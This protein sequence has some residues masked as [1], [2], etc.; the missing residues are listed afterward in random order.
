MIALALRCM[1]P[2]PSARLHNAG[3]VAK[4]VH[5]YMTSVDERARE[6]RL[7]AERARARAAAERKARKEEKKAEKK[8][9]RLAERRAERAAGGVDEAGR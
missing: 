1:A 8:A 9:A 6:A 2:A 7:E 4:A 3:A 5:A